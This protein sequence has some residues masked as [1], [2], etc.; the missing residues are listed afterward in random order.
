ML[1]Q[2]RKTTKIPPLIRGKNIYET[3]CQQA[4]SCHALLLSNL[5]FS[6]LWRPCLGFNFSLIS[7]DLLSKKAIR[8]ISFSE[9][10]SHSV[11]LF[12]SLNLLKL[13]DVIELQ[14]LSFVYQWSHRLLPPCCSEY[15][16]FTSFVHSY[17]T[18][19]SCNRNLY[20][21]SVSTT[22]YSL[23]SLKFTG[24]GL[25]N[26]LP[27]SLIRNLLEHFVKP[28]RT[29]CLIVILFNYLP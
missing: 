2:T 14:I 5:S 15:F 17:S 7:N 22:Q 20:V 3:F 8:L 19:Q 28:W 29:Q 12:K 27:T 10:K 11:P 4:Y 25:W 6:H 13:N 16:R 24:P 26:T 23:R 1:R 9:P 18:R 21:T